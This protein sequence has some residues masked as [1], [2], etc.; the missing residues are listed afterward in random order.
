MMCI[1][2]FERG[3]I[4]GIKNREIVG[5]VIAKNVEDLRRK[6]EASGNPEL[7]AFAGALDKHPKHGM[8]KLPNGDVLLVDDDTQEPPRV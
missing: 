6:C 1:V 8:Y 3:I 7:T 2:G 4:R 5:W